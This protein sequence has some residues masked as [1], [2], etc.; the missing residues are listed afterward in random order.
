VVTTHPESSI[1]VWD[2]EEKGKS[3]IIPLE[4][5]AIANAVYMD[6]NFIIVGNSNGILNLRER[7]SGAFLYNLNR[8]S[9]GEIKGEVFINSS[10]RIN[11]IERV[12]RWVL[13]GFESSTLT[14]Y[15][16][17]QQSAEFPIAEYRFP[18]D[19]GIKS[20]LIESCTILMAAKLKPSSN[21]A[22]KK[23][24]N[25][26]PIIVSWS[27]RL[28]GF[29]FFSIILNIMNNK[30]LNS[31]VIPLY[32]SFTK[33]MNMLSDIG[34]CKREDV[35]EFT[36]TIESVQD[37]INLLI[38][39]SSDIRIPFLLIGDLQKMMD[40]YEEL[41]LKLS[42]SGSLTKYLTNNRLRKTIEL[43]NMMLYQKI[44]E[45]KQVL[46]ALIHADTNTDGQ[47]RKR[48]FLPENSSSTPPPKH[49]QNPPQQQQ[50]LQQQLPQALQIP[51][52]SPSAFSEKVYQDLEILKEFK[53]RIK[54]EMKEETEEDENGRVTIY[55]ATPP[56]LS[57]DT[58]PRMATKAS[59]P[60]TTAMNS[61]G[62]NG[63]GNSIGVKNT[64]NFSPTR[65]IQRST[66]LPTSREGNNNR[67][68]ET[69]SNSY[70]Y[71]SN[72]NSNSSSIDEAISNEN[73]LPR[74]EMDE[75]R[76]IWERE[77]PNEKSMVSWAIFSDAIKK[78]LSVQMSPMDEKI[79]RHILDNMVTG[80]V[81]KY[82][83][84][85]FLKVFGPFSQCVVNL[86]SVLS[87]RWFQGFL[88]ARESTLLLLL[89]PDGTYLI[90]FS[91][92]H[93]GSFSLAF[94]FNGAVNHILISTNSPNGFKVFEEDTKSYREFKTLQEI[95]SYYNFVLKIPYSSTVPKERWFQGDLSEEDADELLIS[96]T[97]G[98]YMI[99]LIHF[100][101]FALS[102]LEE[103][104]GNVKRVRH[105]PIVFDQE[106]GQF[107]VQWNTEAQLPFSSL[108]EVVNHF[109]SMNILKT[110]FKNMSSIF[111]EQKHKTSRDDHQ[112][113]KK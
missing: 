85:E 113:T 75:G 76:F 26:I 6:D 46:I 70:N 108:K 105:V 100:C 40:N 77:F 28:E 25:P 19:A 59:I 41:L 87:E 51:K 29:D 79:L 95:V 82:K 102:F 107:L 53:A 91:K 39:Y 98:T 35:S 78:Y 12:G 10:G 2:L 93:P 88:S 89:E 17:H 57:Q 13:C 38:Q 32:F 86:K 99:R 37:V 23:N 63:T 97:P 30:S 48:T 104:D 71:N 33:I 67:L 11:C 111:M 9:V 42:H 69:N 60:T 66:M 43:Q 72:S 94:K 83:F 74:I 64:S 24:F 103:V 96:Q 15:D 16:L 90:R 49:L 68:N 14:I 3:S 18:K 21:Q 110:P 73:A 31:H 4:S 106:S 61:G 92:T 7:K 101:R 58:I 80:Y 44:I 1:C 27:P 45:V 50:Q 112:S 52:S 5:K 56:L 22:G 47:L 109:L 81:T 65:K 34:I 55:F 62:T 84:S 20:I 8:I 54:K 36:S